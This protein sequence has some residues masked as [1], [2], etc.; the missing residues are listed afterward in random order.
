MEFSHYEE[1]PSMLSEK[2]VNEARKEKE[3]RAAEK[4]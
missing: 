4:H 1:L 3:A 2:V